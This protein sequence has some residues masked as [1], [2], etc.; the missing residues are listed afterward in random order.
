MNRIC[1]TADCTCDLPLD[2]LKKYNVDLIY[3]Y[4]ITSSGKFRDLDEITATNIF[5]YHGKNGGKTDTSPPFPAEFKEFFKKK[6]EKY[7]EVIHITISSKIS[8]GV[9][10][11]EEAVRQLGEDGKRVHVFDSLHLSTGMGHLVVA[12]AKMAEEGKNSEE[13]ISFISEMRSRVSTSF[14]AMNA[15]QLYNNGLVSKTVKN[16]CNYLSIHPVLYMKEGKLKLKAV[17]MGNYERCI[18][19]YVRS[20][21]RNSAKIKKDLMFIT[22]SGCLLKDIRLIQREVNRIQTFDSL[23]VSKASAT[24][25]GNCGP[26]T[27]GLLYVFE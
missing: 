22:H 5:E 6:L 21:L 4:I 1:I 23:L 18:I 11:A 12:A 8:A 2:V 20:E 16:V 19:R 9:E 3:Y 25:S 7:D 17:K 27:V 26:R 15:N 24:I 13:I 14:I 10:H